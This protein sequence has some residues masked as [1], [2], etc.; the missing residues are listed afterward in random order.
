VDQLPPL[1]TTA[2]PSLSTAAQNEALAHETCVRE[3]K[4]SMLRPAVQLLPLY[5]YS[6]P[7]LSTATQKPRLG[8]DTEFMPVW[9]AIVDC[10][11]F[12]A[13]PV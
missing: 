10:A 11:Q 5:V 8:Q 4:L 6:L 9:L 7:S 12:V 3:L 1:S 2:F 13:E